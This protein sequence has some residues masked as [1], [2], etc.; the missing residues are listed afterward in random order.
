MPSW[1]GQE[2]GMQYL[3]VATKHHEGFAMYRYRRTPAA[4]AT[5][6]PSTGM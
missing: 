4:S 5:P 3:V 1:T 2:C 6:P